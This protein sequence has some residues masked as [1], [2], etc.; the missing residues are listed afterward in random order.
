M[1]PRYYLTAHAETRFRERAG[2]LTFDPWSRRMVLVD[3]IDRSRLTGIANAE[4]ARGERILGAARMHIATSSVQRYGQFSA[5]DELVAFDEHGWI[6]RRGAIS[7]FFEVTPDM[8]RVLG[9]PNESIRLIA[10][11]EVCD[12]VLPTKLLGEA[13]TDDDRL[14][15]A[16]RRVIRAGV[17]VPPARS[18]TVR[19][20]GPFVAERR[21]HG[22]AQDVPMTVTCDVVHGT[23]GNVV[24]SV[25]CR[26]RPFVAA[27]YAN[28]A[29]SD[30]PVGPV[31]PED[32]LGLRHGAETLR[33]RLDN[34]ANALARA[35]GK[36]VAWWESRIVRAASTVRPLSDEGMERFF[37]E[38]QGK[39]R[40]ERPVGFALHV[41][42]ACLLEPKAQTLLLLAGVGPRGTGQA[43]RYAATTMSMVVLGHLNYLL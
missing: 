15:D 10:H 36:S 42:D 14:E 23:N 41:P 8:F 16:L 18:G 35:S 9:W 6:L 20:V 31:A 1:R 38:E 22:V 33:I 13:V 3:E 28:V 17:E 19:F 32:G 4:I 5:E 2:P 39:A 29:A 34:A 7:S 12:Q 30:E 43:R 11:Q 40:P 37:P 21:V 25:E 26:L 27:E 24:R